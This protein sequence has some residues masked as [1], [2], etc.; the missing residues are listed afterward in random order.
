MS[1]CQSLSALT[2]HALWRT[3]HGTPHATGLDADF[4]GS[5]D[6]AQ[7]KT[8]SEVLQGLIHAGAT[9]RRGEKSAAARTFR[10]ALD[11][12]LARQGRIERALANRPQTDG[13]GDQP[14]APGTSG[15]NRVLR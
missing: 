3:R 10:E 11:W 2:A 15:I 5:G 1:E 8:A 7:I 12:L 14:A 6:Y 4:L 13:R 9:V